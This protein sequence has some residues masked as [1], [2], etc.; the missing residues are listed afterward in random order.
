MIDGH[1][2]HAHG[3]I[4][5]QATQVRDLAGQH[6][7]R[8]TDSLKQYA[9]DYSAKAQSLLNNRG[10]MSSTVKSE[11]FPA[12]PQHEPVKTESGAEPVAAY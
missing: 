3:V 2:N 9:G 11:E 7:G 5:A 8:A 4:S 12:A 1:L 6:T 10:G